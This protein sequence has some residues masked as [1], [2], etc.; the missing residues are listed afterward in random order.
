MKKLLSITL[1]F[2]GLLSFVSCAED[3]GTTEEFAE[4]QTKN[5]T[6]WSSLYTSTLQRMASGN[7]SVD[8]IRKWSLQN[9][10]VFAGITTTYAPE[11]YIIVE[12]LV[13]GTGEVSPAYSDSVAVHYQGRL[14]PSTTY[15]SGYI[16]DKST[17]W[18]DSYNLDIMK[19]SSFAVSGLVDGFTTALLKMHVG[20]R[21]KVYIPYQLGYGTSTSSSSSIPAYSTLIFDITLT[22]IWR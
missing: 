6:Y 18:N 19:P 15:T 17:G 3:E 8:T 21:W 5:E 20:D 13:N 4:W 14:I 11:D 1:L 10:T 7:A 22:K 12:K 16:F 9:Q 2:C